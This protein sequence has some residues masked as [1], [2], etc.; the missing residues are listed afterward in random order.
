MGGTLFPS[1]GYIKI[2]FLKIKL[3]KKRE[4]KS[5]IKKKKGE[6]GNG[7][8]FVIA[9]ECAGRDRWKL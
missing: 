1:P 8:E 4:T 9:S 5:A 7:L 2:L 3:N 6:K